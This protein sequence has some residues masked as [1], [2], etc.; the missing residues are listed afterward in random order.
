VAAFARFVD[1][2]P[3]GSREA[4]VARSRLAR[5]AAAQGAPELAVEH[6][7][8]IRD[9]TAQTAGWTALAGWTVLADWTAL[10]AARSLSSAGEAEDVG[11]L[12]ALVES[13]SGLAMGW[14]LEMDAWAVA[15]DTA[16]ALESLVAVA[17]R[18]EESA[19]ATRTALLDREWRFRL[20]VGDSAGSVAAMEDL[21]RQTTRTSAATQAATSASILGA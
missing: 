9:G 3:A 17:P 11:V 8:A 16:R 2:A 10:A 19:P 18:I 14:A 15:R 1:A 5:A 7:A 12:L 4:L 13:P 20:A 21:L 6:V